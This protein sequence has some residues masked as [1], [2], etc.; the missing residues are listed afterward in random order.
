[1][2][3]AWLTAQPQWWRRG[4]THVAIDLSASYAKAVR[5]GLPDAVLVADRFHI[6]RLAND[7]VTGVRQRVIREDQGRRGR[8]TDP[9]WRVR[10]RLPTADERLRP[11]AFTKMWNTLVDTGSPGQEILHA[12]VVKE[13]LRTLLA[14]SAPTSNATSSVALCTGSTPVPPRPAP[15]RFTAS[16]PPSRPGGRRSKPPSSPATPT[17][18]P[19]GYN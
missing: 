19:R 15:R 8:K 14:L 9:A 13:E 5:E 6:I 16:P 10:R 18:A 3:T 17:P 12:Y 1:V 7:T 2:V 4:I 11:Q